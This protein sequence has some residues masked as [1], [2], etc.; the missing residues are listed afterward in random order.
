MGK[1]RLVGRG[2]KLN[3]RILEFAGVLAGMKVVCVKENNLR[4]KE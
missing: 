1:I 2:G 4:L 3:E